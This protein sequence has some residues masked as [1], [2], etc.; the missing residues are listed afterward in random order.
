MPSNS[1]RA[2]LISLMMLSDKQPI[3]VKYK[4]YEM[5]TL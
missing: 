3:W 1:A 2:M 5:A 4:M